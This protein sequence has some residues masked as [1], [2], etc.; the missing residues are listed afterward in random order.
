[1]KY[2]L[3]CV[4]FVCFVCGCAGAIQPYILY[5][6]AG[7]SPEDIVV[8]TS[9]NNAEVKELVCQKIGSSAGQLISMAVVKSV[10]GETGDSTLPYMGQV[11]N[12]GFNCQFE[13]QL[14]PGKHQLVV[15]PN[16]Y[17]ASGRDSVP[18]TIN[19]LAGHH[20]F[21]GNILEILQVPSLGVRGKY[22]WRPFIVDMTT[23]EMVSLYPFISH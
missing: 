19:A 20:Y 13:I 22:R 23:N 1:M 14:M 2:L 5:S 21:I 16:C 15:L 7:V 6:D 18:M 9:K 12:S 11:F 4:F 3:V 8:L 17:L 10:D